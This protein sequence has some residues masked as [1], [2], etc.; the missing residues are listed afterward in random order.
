MWLVF[1]HRQ[2]ILLGVNENENDGMMKM[3]LLL[4]LLMF[5][6]Y[7]IGVNILCLKC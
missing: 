2:Y 1:I 5:S 7:R 6:M 3:V 4:Q